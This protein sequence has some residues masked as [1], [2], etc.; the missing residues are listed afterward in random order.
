MNEEILEESLSRRAMKSRIF[1]LENR[2]K[3]YITC[4]R[5]ERKALHKQ[6]KELLVANNRLEKEIKQYKQE[7]ANKLSGLLSLGVV[8]T[9]K[10]NRDYKFKE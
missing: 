10:I 3:D 5:K 7:E 1:Y 6:L 2:M 9:P 8:Y 4:F